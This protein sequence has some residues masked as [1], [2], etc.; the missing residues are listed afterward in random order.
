MTSWRSGMRCSRALT[1]RSKSLPPGACSASSASRA[2]CL[3]HG[4]GVRKPGH[5]RGLAAVY[6]VP[7][8]G[9]P[10]D[11]RCRGW[12]KLLR[13]SGVHGKRKPGISVFRRD[14]GF[15]VYCHNALY[16]ADKTAASGILGRPSRDGARRHSGGNAHY[17]QYEGKVQDAATKVND[18]H[19]KFD[20]E[21]FDALVEKKSSWTTTSA[22]GFG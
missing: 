8:A 14:R 5:I 12:G 21:L 16:K 20:A 4:R 13:V 3:L 22:C 9:A 7:R 19:L 2:F 6:D 15:Y 17:A 18:T 11:G 1:T 10:A